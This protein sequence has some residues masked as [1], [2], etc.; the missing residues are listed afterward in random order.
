METVFNDYKNTLTTMRDNILYKTEY[1]DRDSG[2]TF[3][4]CF[5]PSTE[6]LTQWPSKWTEGAISIY[7][8]TSN[9]MIDTMVTVSKVK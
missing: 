5:P 7:R 9:D 2:K 4:L 1:K 6:N 3:S 8:K